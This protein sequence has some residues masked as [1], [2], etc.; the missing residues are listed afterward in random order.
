MAMKS[1]FHKCLRS[2]FGEEQYLG[3]VKMCKEEISKSRSHG[4]DY[5]KKSVYQSMYKILQNESKECIREKSKEA[6][7]AMY[8]AMVI[9]NRFFYIVAFYIIAN[10]ILINLNLEYYVTCGS[11]FLI[12]MAFLYKLVEFLTNK[13][14]FID[15]YLIMVYKAALETLQVK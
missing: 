10:I 2:H 13:Y 5:R 1:I 15:A 12:G 7:D 14:C 3:F 9:R 11:I 8:R 4:E 6:S